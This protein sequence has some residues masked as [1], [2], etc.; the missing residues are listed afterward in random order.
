MPEGF[1]GECLSPDLTPRGLSL[2]GG[3]SGPGPPGDAKG[4]DSVVYAA[5]PGSGR[6]TL[7]NAETQRPESWKGL[8]WGVAGQGQPPSVTSDRLEPRVVWHMCPGA[9][10]WHLHGKACVNLGAP[11]GQSRYEQE[12]HVGVAVSASPASPSACCH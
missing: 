12:A 9:C 5:Q 7:G 11:K 8:P 10:S 3:A 6:A 1:P 4:R 2:G